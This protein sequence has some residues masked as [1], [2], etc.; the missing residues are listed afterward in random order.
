MFCALLSAV[1]CCV[2]LCDVALCCDALLYALICSVGGVFI[3]FLS[4]GFLYALTTMAF[5]ANITKLMGQSTPS[6]TGSMFQQVMDKQ[7]AMLKED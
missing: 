3:F 1:R 6:D 4:Q 2:A 5:R 7:Q